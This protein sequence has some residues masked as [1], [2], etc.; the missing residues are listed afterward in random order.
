M[1]YNDQI[2]YMAETVLQKIELNSELQEYQEISKY[3]S[4]PYPEVSQVP[5]HNLKSY[6]SG[7]TNMEDT[8]HA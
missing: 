2:M 7:T 1:D 8:S 5:E 3:F 6:Y 4:L